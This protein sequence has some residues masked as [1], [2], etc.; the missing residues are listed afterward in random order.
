MSGPFRQDP[1]DLKGDDHVLRSRLLIL[2]AAR[3][4][5]RV[6]TVIGA[7]GFGKTTLLA[8]AVEQNR[9]S[10]RGLDVWVGC[11]ADDRPVS[12]AESMLVGLGAEPGTTD[13]SAAAQVADA[14][15]AL[16]PTDVC[17]MLDDAHELYDDPACFDFLSA[18]IKQMPNNAHL[19]LSSRDSVPLPLSR[20]RAAGDLLEVDQSLLAFDA[21]EISEFGERF[22]A[23][24]DPESSELRW[25]ALA[26]LS[27]QSG[28][29]AAAEFVWEEVLTELEPARRDALLRISPFAFIDDE[30]VHAVSDW[31]GPAVDLVAGLPLIAQS[32]DHRFRLHALWRPIL[33]SKLPQEARDEAARRGAQNLLDRGEF[34]AAAEAF[35]AAGDSAGLYETASELC[36][37]PITTQR[38]GGAHRIL[39]LVEG[40]NDDDDRIEGL[41]M[42][43]RGV[44]QLGG[45]ETGA[46][47]TLEEA[48]KR[49]RDAGEHLLEIRVLFMASQL[50]GLIDG[51][52][53]APHLVPRARE[54][55]ESDDAAVA[56][57]GRAMAARFEMYSHL[58]AGRLDEGFALVEEMQA[59]GPVRGR[60]LIDQFA[61]DAG[62]PERMDDYGPRAIPETGD[63]PDLDMAASLALWVR[64]SVSPELGVSIAENM[65]GLVAAQKISHQSVL[66]RGM[67]AVVAC[68]AGEIET[69]RLNIEQARLLASAD[70]G[71]RVLGY[72]DVASAWVAIAEGDEDEAAA[73]FD[74]LA[75]AVP[76]DGSPPRLFLHSIAPLYILHPAA[77]PL[78]ESLSLGPALQAA[79]EA[80]I[81]LVEYRETGNTDLAAA[82]DWSN[83][84]FLR[85]SLCPPFLAELAL[86]GR[87]GGQTGAKEVLN[88][89]PDQ[90][91]IL[92]QLVAADG[93]VKEAAIDALNDLPE[94]PGFELRIRAL[95]EM[96]IERDGDVVDDSDWLRREK[97]RL[98]F[99]YLLQ[100]PSVARRDLASALWPDQEIDKALANVRANLRFLLRVL[101]PDRPTGADSWFIN[102]DGRTIEL[103]LDR[104][105]V[106]VVEFDELVDRGRRADER[107][108]PSEALA[109]YESAIDL[110]RGDFLEESFQDPWAEF[111][112][113]RLRSAAALAASR[114]GELLLA[115]GEPERAIRLATWA[116]EREPLLERAHRGRI[117]A[118]L[119]QEDRNAARHAAALL[120][121]QLTEAEMEP[122]PDTA[123]M[124]SS[125]GVSGPEL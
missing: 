86:A 53:P 104:V 91:T 92:E 108:V 120:V 2:L 85:S 97:V 125:L 70:F 113:I 33:E 16:A 117:R 96:R 9:L 4:D 26:R 57:L 76:F 64:G 55:A 36:A 78:L 41:A 46:Q 114:V 17:I 75:E 50:S 40:L 69:A 23:S 58:V 100:H 62:W 52:P 18:L 80:A 11:T 59:F 22:D 94:G 8:Q 115:R 63:V 27:V 124:L 14:V 56:R 24:L 10:A 48:A 39:R 90:R 112:R 31:R 106:D 110:Y 65:V 95:G 116:L 105:R 101:E 68:A 98:L 44:I 82:T 29:D 122:E 12:L 72:L 37:A 35:A 47:A 5:A 13:E 3:F 25:P 1:P 21:S 93:K 102:T 66:L 81:A 28:R 38:V 79:I 73:I 121:T 107:G 30:L 32:R 19:L 88:V 89:L 71:P 103:R 74:R 61:V 99:A 54:L 49:L 83:I 118:L 7:A 15:W 67:V 42:V 6:T 84:D 77:R 87:Q 111:E 20:V 109:C 123:S 51:L 45:N 60:M 119:A 34:V 43:L